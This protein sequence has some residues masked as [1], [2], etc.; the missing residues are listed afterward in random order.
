MYHLENI[1]CII[2]IAYGF[3]M[4]I[5]F[6]TYGENYFLLVQNYI[7]LFLVFYFTG[8]FD[9]RM[10]FFS[11]GWFYLIFPSVVPEYLLEWIVICVPIP[12][13]V[14]SRI[15]QIWEL[16]QQKSP[17]SVSIVMNIA[18]TG[19]TIVRIFN[20]IAES[21]DIYILAGYVISLIL[22]LIIV[23]QLLY[24]KHF[25]SGQQRLAL[26]GGSDCSKVSVVAVIDINGVEF[27]DG[28]GNPPPQVQEIN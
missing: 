14:F 26:P 8:K 1:S 27:F 13:N 16:Y 19:G 9:H 22:H 10:M 28:D 2:S 4:A 20:I 6:T 3:R 25:S 12:L 21:F 17:G 18:N 15:P 11:L 7:I 23:S 24:Y 5:P